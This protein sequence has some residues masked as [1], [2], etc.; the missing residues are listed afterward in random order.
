MKFD[1]DN[2]YNNEE[3]NGNGYMQNLIVIM[4]PMLMRIMVLVVMMIVS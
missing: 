2:G 4:V 1:C 3:D